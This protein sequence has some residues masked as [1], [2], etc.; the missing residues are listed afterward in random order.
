MFWNIRIFISDTI[1]CYITAFKN[2]DVPSLGIP[3]VEEFHAIY[4][5]KMGIP[6]V[7]SWD[8]YIA[9][10]LFRFAAILQGVYKRAISGK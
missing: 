3:S 9:F 2:F 4:C 8:F 1:L 10:G 6:S 7:P 5:Q